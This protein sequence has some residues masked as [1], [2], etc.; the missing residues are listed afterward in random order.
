MSAAKN[1]SGLPSLATVDVLLGSSL[2]R[3]RL[4]AT[5]GAAGVALPALGALPGGLRAR[6][7]AVQDTP[8][9]GGT[10]TWADYE[11]NTLNPYIASE[12]IARSVIA[13]VNRGLTG[14]SPDGVV[15]PALA[16]EIPSVENE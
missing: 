3:R 6:A 12:A 9:P 14:V 11:P 4:I 16:A 10:I 7:V 8:T 15:V 13:L 5:A 2:N 1:Q